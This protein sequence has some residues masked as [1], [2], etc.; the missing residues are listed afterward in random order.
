MDEIKNKCRT[1]YLK[2]TKHFIVHFLMSLK[3]LVCVWIVA[4][5]AFKYEVTA[6]P[7]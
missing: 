3:C 7:P 5:K 1:Q 4:F 2:K 6:V